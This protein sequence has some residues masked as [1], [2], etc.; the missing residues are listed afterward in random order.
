VR[1]HRGQCRFV[2][3]NLVNPLSTVR[4]ANKLEEKEWGQQKMQGY[5]NGVLLYNKM[6]EKKFS[7]G[8][9][10]VDMYIVLHPEQVANSLYENGLLD[11]KPTKGD[12]VPLEQEGTDSLER[13]R[14]Q[15]KQMSKHVHRSLSDLESNK[16]KFTVVRD[17]V[18]PTDL[19]YGLVWKTNKKKVLEKGYCF[20]VFN[21]GEGHD[22]F[23]GEGRIVT[24]QKGS[25]SVV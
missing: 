11:A 13:R 24:T 6:L 20:G 23:G 3:M 18:H 10:A 14:V 16:E 19:V 9:C 25:Y 21:A 22:E 15:H 8:S 17:G 4:Y 5:I 12:L 7:A 1:D 2:F